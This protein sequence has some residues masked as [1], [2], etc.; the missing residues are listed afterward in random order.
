MS[1]ADLLGG[2]WLVTGCAG[3]TGP[4]LQR[5]GRNEDGAANPTSSEMTLLH[6]GRSHRAPESPGLW[7]SL[8]IS[9]M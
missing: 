2:V 8:S 3:L 4:A 1:R 7:T 5:S 6:F 9:W